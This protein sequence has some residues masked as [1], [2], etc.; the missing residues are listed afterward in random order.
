MSQEKQN[1]PAFAR[2]MDEVLGDRSAHLPDPD[3]VADAMLKQSFRELELR[4]F[5]DM[6][7]RG[8]KS[9]ALFEAAFQSMLEGKTVMLQVGGL[10][11]KGA[12]PG[13]LIY[14]D[15]YARNSDADRMPHICGDALFGFDMG[16]GPDLTSF[17]IDALGGLDLPDLAQDEP[18]P[19][20]KNGAR[21]NRKTEQ[22]K[23][24]LP[25]YHKNRRF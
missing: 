11:G 9:A 12:S 24:K 21:A 17:L 23:A 19:R 16:K 3:R 13:V 8:G 18:E 14:D 10:R 2:F 15:I 6:L 1:D 5:A 22:A 20:A 4:I 7:Q 25:F